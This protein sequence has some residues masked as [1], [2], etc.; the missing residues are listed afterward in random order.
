MFPPSLGHPFCF[1]QL[2]V[3]QKKKKQPLGNCLVCVGHSWHKPVL[4]A[5]CSFQQVDLTAIVVASCL[6]R[7]TGA[8][9]S[10]SGVCISL[11]TTCSKP[12]LSL[13]PGLC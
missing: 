10:S 12:W 8:L 11:A 7:R 13:V 6:G 4:R 9:Y 3:P 2:T 5:S 1:A